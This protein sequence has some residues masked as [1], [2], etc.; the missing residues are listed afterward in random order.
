MTETVRE[1][2]T[3]ALQKGKFVRL[4][5]TPSHEEIEAARKAL[6][7]IYHE[8]IGR[9]WFGR[10]TDVSLTTDAAYT[11][12]EGE[13]IFNNAPGDVDIT[14]TLPETVEDECT[15]EDRPPKDYSLVVVV[16]DAERSFLYSARTGQWQDLTS[17]ALTTEA[18]LADRSFDGLASYLATRLPYSQIGP[19]EQLSA[20]NFLSLISHKADRARAPTPID[21]Y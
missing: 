18:P 8:A 6:Q 15:G 3:T 20:A 7:S 14:I 16:N 17:L 9:G 12:K 2:C 5:G 21:A 1:V 11:A 13:R 10:L 19:A 4:G